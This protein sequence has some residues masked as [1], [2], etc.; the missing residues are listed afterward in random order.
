MIMMRRR[1]K[2]AN[3]NDN[4]YLMKTVMYDLDDNKAL[5]KWHH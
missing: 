5:L 3:D 2:F 1:R 4:N